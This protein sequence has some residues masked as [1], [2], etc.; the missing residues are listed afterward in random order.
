MSIFRKGSKQEREELEREAQRKDERDQEATALIR[1][2]LD[3]AD[4][5][6]RV[7]REVR[8]KAARF[9]GSL[10]PLTGTKD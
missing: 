7:K 10:R 6:L 4:A 3:A 5:G 2:S 8:E 9:I 1:R